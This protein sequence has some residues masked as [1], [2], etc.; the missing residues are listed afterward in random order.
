LHAISQLKIF[1]PNRLKRGFSMVKKNDVLG[2]ESRISWKTALL[3]SILSAAFVI[4]LMLT[5]S[6][7]DAATV[8]VTGGDGGDNNASGSVS[9]SSGTITNISFT[10][11]APDGSKGGG[12]QVILTD[13]VSG[14]D[15]FLIAGGGGGDASAA[16]GGNGGD[17]IF[18]ENYG[19][20]PGDKSLELD[21]IEIAGGEGGANSA[22]NP[23]SVTAGTG[24][25]ITGTFTN[26]TSLDVQWLYLTGGEGNG[27]AGGNI[28]LNFQNAT[29]ITV[30]D[31]YDYLNF[32]AGAGGAAESTDGYSGGAGGDISFTMA[33]GS[34]ITA[35]GQFF[36]DGGEG[37]DG[38]STN[39]SNGGSGGNTAIN[40]NGGDILSSDSIYIRSGSS[41]T[42]TT[43][44]G[45]G[46]RSGTVTLNAGS[47]EVDDAT[48]GYGILYIQAMAGSAQ[49]D[50]E[51][52]AVTVEIE[53]AIT[54]NGGYGFSIM[55]GRGKAG[56]YDGG[57]VKVSAGSIDNS[58]SGFD[59]YGGNAVQT[60]SGGNILLL[61]DSSLKST[62][63]VGLGV[64]GAAAGGAGTGDDV[65]A[66]GGNITVSGRDADSEITMELDAGLSVI[67]GNGGA[68][69][70]TEQKDGGK[71]GD[72]TMSGPFKKITV[73]GGNY[74]M[75]AP[76]NGGV[77]SSLANTGSALTSGSGGNAVFES[78]L[79]TE[80]D[81]TGTFFAGGGMGGSADPSVNPAANQNAGTGGKA[82]FNVPGAVI[83]A[84]NEI[85]IV[86]GA[87][88]NGSSTVAANGGDGGNLDF[89]IGSGTMKS[90][91]VDIGG[92]VGGT[93]TTGQGTGGRSGTLNLT[94]GTI[95]STGTDGIR[96]HTGEGSAAADPETDVVTVTVG[97]L[98]TVTGNGALTIQSGDGVDAGY[99]GGNLAVTVGKITS[100]TGDIDVV[101]GAAAAK[102]SGDVQLTVSAEINST[103]DVNVAGGASSGAANAGSVDVDTPKITAANVTLEG[104]ARSAAGA[105]SNVKLSSTSTDTLA[106]NLTGGLALKGG[107]GTGAS[108]KGGTAT[109]DAENEVDLSGDLSLG[110]SGSTTTSGEVTLSTNLLKMTGD[111]TWDIYSAGGVNFNADDVLIQGT[112]SSALRTVT[113]GTLAGPAAF[114]LPQITLGGYGK[115]DGGSTSDIGD[116][117]TLGDIVVSGTGNIIDNVE[118]DYSD[119]DTSPSFIFD[120]A[121]S[122]DGDSMLTVNNG[123]FNFDDKTFDEVATIKNEDKLIDIL[124]DNGTISFFSGDAANSGVV[125]NLE[126]STLVLTRGLE[127]YTVEVGADTVSNLAP[128]TGGGSYK[129][130]FEGA[131]A[132]ALAV[133]EAATSAEETIA[134]LAAAAE[135]GATQIQMG[136]IAQ[137]VTNKTGSKVKVKQWG[138][139]LAAGHK[140]ETGAG[141]LTFGAFVE[142]GHGDYNTYNSMA[143]LGEVRGKGDTSYFGGG[144]FIRHD[145]AQGTWLSLTG[146][147]GSVKNKYHLDDIFGNG[148]RYSASSSYWGLNFGVGQKIAVSDSGT[149]DIYGR[150]FWTRVSAETVSDGRGGSIHFDKVTSLRTRVG[151]RYT[152]NFTDMVSGFFGLAWEYEGKG[153][154]GGTYVNSAGNVFRSDAPSLKGSSG[155]GE[156]GV[157]IAAA[158][159]VAFEI[160][161][162]GLAGQSKGGGGEASLIITF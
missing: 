112:S 53:K 25:N 23:A 78:T 97:E 155:Y 101:A 141:A 143:L 88:K 148:L 26:L 162:F 27:A 75:F 151:A 63:L 49:S 41:G 39:T 145:F 62:T 142:G 15:D 95:T 28:S 9:L 58:V 123:D 122:K 12:V 35:A 111:S 40:L 154:A 121:N 156:I 7:A 14:S 30:T 160:S 152:H 146:R 118:L 56:G 50:P 43:G 144:L 161:G 42:S 81:I 24:G 21:S 31:E 92:S 153:N 60:K 20:N 126:P 107:A 83:N 38:S 158:E 127:V 131:A 77:A 87:A 47:L 18:S 76:G 135:A 73:D 133:S 159:N 71:G 100:G 37:K 109:V 79:A 80:F 65:G 13:D 19:V 129:P 120:L 157:K 149:F 116:D 139:N 125:E 8:T 84:T 70:G 114:A 34:S 137:S 68:A 110:D 106:L 94:A 44:K 33:S 51:S 69:G 67:P 108:A 130:Y 72:V 11:V 74:F 61:L 32:E 113:L 82:I 46:G 16:N 17:I 99:A 5:S 93:S 124:A 86:A 36:I 115:L 138:L 103:G 134:E 29:T 52:Y 105:G 57:N 54:S 140:T 147:A 150:L 6:T 48:G 89:N 85:D 119:P 64:Y 96:I 132:A 10:S 128:V 102:A 136:F 45:N 104:G 1:S 59:L 90:A 117:Y 4:M 55:A 2:K 98:N 91:K 22:A 3:G 66:A